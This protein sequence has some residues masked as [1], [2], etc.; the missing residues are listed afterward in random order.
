[1][2]IVEELIEFG[3]LLYAAH[4]VVK[5]YYRPATS[6]GQALPDVLD[7][8]PDVL[9]VVVPGDVVDIVEEL[10]QALE[11]NAEDVAS[12]ISTTFMDVGFWN[13]FEKNIDDLTKIAEGDRG[14]IQ[15]EFQKNGV[16]K[17][18]LR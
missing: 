2:D 5:P 10:I 17:K 14:E 13:N 4:D 6:E 3:P 18:V 11:L 9:D 16:A 15:K 1:M 8:F 12:S 7:T